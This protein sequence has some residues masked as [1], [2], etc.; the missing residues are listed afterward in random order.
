MRFNYSV[1]LADLQNA[2]ELHWHQT[3]YRRAVYYSVNWLVPV[4][5]SAF[6]ILF[7]S[8]EGL[9]F[10]RLPVMYVFMLGFAISA[11]IRTIRFSHQKSKMYR[12]RFDKT[13]P[14][15]KRN[16][17]CVVDDEGITSAIIGTAEEKW[18]WQAILHFAQNEKITLM[19][20]SAK[21]FLFIPTNALSSD[22]RSELLEYVD[23]HMR[24]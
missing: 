2:Q 15:H 10:E 23:R 19:Y 4:L 6:V 12:K 9:F 16:A 13:F 11:I 17:W 20:V 22:Q 24:R 1:T 14:P 18:P 7:L 5:I 21:K 8:R 3:L